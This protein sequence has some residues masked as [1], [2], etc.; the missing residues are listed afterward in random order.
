MAK[1]WGV[2][3]VIGTAS[4]QNHEYVRRLGSIPVSYG[5]GLRV[6]A[7]AHEGVDAAL[8]AAGPEALIAFI[9]EKRIDWTTQSRLIC[10]VE[11]GH[12]QGKVVFI[13][14]YMLF[15]KKMFFTKFH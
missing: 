6:L 3:T 2:T 15:N 12:G 4:E 8:N 9:S 10:A 13:V 14:D 1:A 7:I 5:E 11:S